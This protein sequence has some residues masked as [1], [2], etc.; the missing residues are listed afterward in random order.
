MSATYVRKAITEP[1]CAG[2]QGIAV[3]RVALKHQVPVGDAAVQ[4]QH[5]RGMVLGRHN[6]AHDLTRRKLR[7]TSKLSFFRIVVFFRRFGASMF[8]HLGGM[9]GPVSEAEPAWISRCLSKKCIET[10][11]A[12]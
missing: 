6:A 4:R 11:G 7:T 2:G 9:W 1:I 12:S 10:N 3:R 5:R 8:K